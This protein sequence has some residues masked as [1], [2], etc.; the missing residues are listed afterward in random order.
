MDS[1]LTITDSTFEHE[2]LKSDSPVLVDFWASWCMPCKMVGPI[3]DEL[4]KEYKGKMKFAKVNV[5]ENSGAP[6][7]FGIMSIP[8]LIIFKDGKP[9][10]TMIGVQPKD[11]FKKNIDEVLS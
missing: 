4:A 10:K 11:V 8:T 5:D 2:V 7:S 6:S 9:V 3:V 1:I